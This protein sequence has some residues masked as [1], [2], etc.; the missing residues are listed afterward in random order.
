MKNTLTT[1]LALLLAPLAALQAADASKPEK[2]PNVLLVLADDMGF[3]DLNCYGSEVRTPVLDRLAAGGL[4]F[5]QFYNCGR[6]QPSRATLL[7]GFYAQQVNRDPGARALEAGD[8]NR[9]EWAALLPALLKPAGYRSYH[10]GKWHLDGSVLA[11]GFDHSYHVADQMRYFGPQRHELDD[12]PLPRPGKGYYATS[13]IATHAVDWLARHDQDHKG[14]PFFLYL[15]FT[16]PHYPLMAPA[17]DIA[18]Y[19]EKFSHGW[20]VERETRLQK[21]KR[22]GLV[23]CELSP[24]E[25]EIFPSWNESEAD[26]KRVIGDKEV[27]RALPWNRL[28]LEQRRFQAEKMAVHATMIDR[29]DREIGRVIEQ[30]KAMGGFENTLILFASDNGASA[31]MPFGGDGHQIDAAPGSAQSFLGLGPG[32]SSAANTPFRRHKAWVH[33]GGVATPLIIHWPAGIKAA[34]ELR[35]TAGHLVDLVPTVLELAGVPVPGEWNGE[36][37]PPLPG[38]SLVPAFAAER[39]IARDFLWFSHQG[40]RALRV[41]DWKIAAAGPHSPWELY[42]LRTD[43]SEI[44]N[45]AATDPGKVRDLAATW[46]AHDGEFA[47]QR[48]TRKTL[49]KPAKAGKHIL[50]P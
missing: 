22:L 37:R 39:T 24:L 48:A 16:A 10:S 15:A 38:R 46:E 30:L 32:W 19:R 31:E 29:M 8:V 42:D 2:K 13:A 21:M 33:E 18:R 14:S 44:C 7:T 35:H 28:S 49:G 5:T 4:R 45:L 41:G 47:K 43:R 17:E 12:V 9:P 20:E 6:C 3:S 26:L 40:N 50:V 1:L 23:S 34:G 36:A 27:A 11:G 25:P